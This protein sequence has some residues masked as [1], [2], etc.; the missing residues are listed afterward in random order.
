MSAIQLAP[1]PVGCKHARSPREQLLGMAAAARDFREPQRR[2]AVKGLI[3]GRYRG[4]VDNGALAFPSVPLCSEA[5]IFER[6]YGDPD[7]LDYWDAWFFDRLPIGELTK[8]V[9]VHAAQSEHALPPLVSHLRKILEGLFPVSCKEAVEYL[10]A[11]PDTRELV[12]GSLKKW[13]VEGL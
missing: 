5:E 7:G 9:A 13:C 3:H 6:A 11:H 8:L 4:M 12:P 10:I 1:A 2:F